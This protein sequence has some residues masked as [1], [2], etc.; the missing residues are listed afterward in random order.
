MTPNSHQTALE[1]N[2]SG[3]QQ[4]KPP[5]S[6]QITAGPLYYKEKR[7]VPFAFHVQVRVSSGTSHVTT[8]KNSHRRG[9]RHQRR[10]IS[11]GGRETETATKETLIT[12]DSFQRRSR[13]GGGWRWAA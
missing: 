6:Q 11:R 3:D 13:G 1:S 7:H 12:L 9:E 5:R 10:P 4:I 2:F 8:W